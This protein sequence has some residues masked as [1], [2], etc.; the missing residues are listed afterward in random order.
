MSKTHRRA[1]HSSK[2]TCTSDGS[3]HK[4]QQ[5]HPYKATKK[6]VLV[7]KEPTKGT[8]EPIWGFGR[9]PPRVTLAMM[10]KED[11]GRTIANNAYHAPQSKHHYFS[12]SLSR[13]FKF[14]QSLVLFQEK[15]YQHFFTHKHV[16][17]LP[18]KILAPSIFLHNLILHNPTKQ[19]STNSFVQTIYFHDLIPN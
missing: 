11:H 10:T 14:S 15:C 17:S 2:I 8:R 13:F 3:T 5:K 1:P 12:L 16:S 19:I 6:L 4:G 18:F 7:I 9:A